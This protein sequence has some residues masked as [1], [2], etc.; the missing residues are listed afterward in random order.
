M[1]DGSM[2]GTRKRTFMAPFQGRSVRETS[3]AKKTPMTV[4]KT[5][6]PAAMMMEFFSAS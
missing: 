5:V 6:V 3:H 4:L 1:K 2:N